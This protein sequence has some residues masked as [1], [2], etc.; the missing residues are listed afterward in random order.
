[1]SWSADGTILFGQPAGIM[2][3]P[4]SGGIPQLVIKTKPTEVVYGPSMLP[5][6]KT[7]LYTATSSALSETRWDQAEIRA[8]ALD[9]IEPK[10]LLRGGSD[11]RY[12]PTGHLV[13]AVGDVLFA[14]AFDVGTLEVKGGPVALISDVQRATNPVFNTAAANFAF[15]D[16]GA[17]AYLHALPSSAEQTTLAIFDRSGAFRRLDVPPATY[18]SPRASPDGTRIAVESVGDNGQSL[19]WIYDLAGRTAIRRLTQEGSNT[20]P[21]WT[22]DGKRVA[23]GSNREKA[24]G[25]YW[26]SA[27]GSALP[28][29]LTTA[30]DGFV[31][32]PE[33]FSPD[34]R[35]LSFGAVRASLGPGSWSLWTLAIDGAT[36]KASLFYD[37]AAS[38]EF[39]SAFSPDGQW[40][41]YASTNEPDPRFAIYIQPYPPTGVKYEISKTGG[42]WP[43]WS[44]DGSELFYRPNV[45]ESNGGRLKAVRIATKPVP[46]FTGDRDL[47][48]RGS[49]SVVNYREYDILPNGKEFVMVI[50][51]AQAGAS[52]AAPPRRISVVV[53]WFEELKAR[54]PGR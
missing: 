7:V 11:A 25:I 10:V 31:H 16:H 46:T 4:A 41:A 34:G 24:H 22:R 54:V 3:V 28:E 51:A 32:F 39:G 21:T 27:D 48:V 52:A 2:R 8:Q 20:R 23:Y 13:Y 50:P 19:I 6:G 14:V 43:V 37:V 17:F 36:K 33:S 29:R 38:N 40:I 45:L 1:V 9:S 42:A 49:V 35:V 26:Q 30:E 18:R 44:P 12:V 15:S 47:P 5:D 53:N